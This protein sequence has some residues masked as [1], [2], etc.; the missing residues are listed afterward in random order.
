MRTQAAIQVLILAV[1]ISYSVLSDTHPRML[2][3]EDVT[4]TTATLLGAV[5]AAVAWW[6]WAFFSETRHQHGF[7]VALLMPLAPVIIPALWIIFISID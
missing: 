2:L 7:W 6:A 1:S 3:T 4:E 5:V